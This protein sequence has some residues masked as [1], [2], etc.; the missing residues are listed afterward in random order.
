MVIRR[1]VSRLSYSRRSPEASAV[2]ALQA[3]GAPLAPGM[4]IGYVVRDASRWLVQVE[5]EA[6]EFDVP[7]Y[8]NL[9]E[10]AWDEVAFTLD[11]VRPARPIGS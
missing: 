3:M 7:Y 5:G 11:R 2:A 4:E 8:V 9:L 6:T 10:K 1:R